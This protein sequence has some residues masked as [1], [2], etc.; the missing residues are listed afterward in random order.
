M[1]SFL[2]VIISLRVTIILA[3]NSINAFLVI[4]GDYMHIY[5]TH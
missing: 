4:I 1:S 5:V 2:I 3:Y